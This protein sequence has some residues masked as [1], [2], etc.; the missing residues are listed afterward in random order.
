MITKPTVLRAVCAVLISN[1]CA[2]HIAFAQHAPAPAS[3]P[4][5]SAVSPVAPLAAPVGGLPMAASSVAIAGKLDLDNVITVAGETVKLH[6]VF[7]RGG[8]PVN[9]ASLQFKVDGASVGQGVTGANGAT[10]VPYKLIDSLTLGAH[11]IHVIFPGDSKTSATNASAQLT[12]LKSITSLTAPYLFEYGPPFATIRGFLRGASADVR[13]ANR[14]V[15]LKDNGAAV[16]TRTTGSDGGF[17]FGI[18]PMNGHKY[19][20][21]FDGE[22]NYLGTTKVAEYAGPQ[23][24]LIKLP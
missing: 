11:T 19:T 15:T 12:V 24:G 21:E 10:D 5:R 3:T 4:V 9:G 16:E 8:V 23:G 14:K 17:V 2:T 22:T 13:L 6:A 20:V 18:E 7:I 1:L